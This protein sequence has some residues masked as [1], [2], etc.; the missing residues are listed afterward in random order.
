MK[1]IPTLSFGQPCSN[2]GTRMSYETIIQRENSCIQTNDIATHMPNLF[3]KVVKVLIHCVVSSS[4]IQ[5]CQ[6]KL[7]GNQLQS[8]K[9]LTNQT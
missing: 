6:G 2:Q 5:I 3:F 9:S 7:L 4:C 8:H 1:K